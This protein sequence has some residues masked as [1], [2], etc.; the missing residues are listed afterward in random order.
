VY[1]RLNDIENL[2]VVT[3]T[4]SIAEVKNLIATQTH[5]PAVADMFNGRVDDQSGRLVAISTKVIPINASLKDMATYTGDIFLVAK[6]AGSRS[7]GDV[8]PT[9]R[10][11]STS[12]SGALLADG[13]ESRK[14][15]N[16]GYVSVHAFLIWVCAVVAMALAAKA[17]DTKFWWGAPLDEPFVQ[18]QCAVNAIIVVVVPV[19]VVAQLLKLNL[20]VRIAAVVEC[21]LIC[22]TITSGIFS[23]TKYISCSGVTLCDYFTVSFYLTW[24]VVTLLLLKIFATVK[25]LRSRRGTQQSH[26]HL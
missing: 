1:F 14:I 25:I 2:V 24:F 15:V 10:A 11:S 17:I 20:D 22:L 21:I 26:V 3:P 23:S 13:T 7:T 9:I 16:A 5:V 4:T 12:Y 18:F 19:F 6:S 8:D